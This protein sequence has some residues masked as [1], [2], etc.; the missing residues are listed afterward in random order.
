MFSDKSRYKKTPV[1]DAL[2][3]GG[4]AVKAVAPRVL[5]A[6]TGLPEVVKTN[7]R[8]D[9]TAFQ[10]LNDPL[11]FWRIADANS[12]LDARGLTA[13]PGETINVPES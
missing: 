10:R 1:I 3:P 13:E 4:K 6:T 12:A 8:L 9:L 5:P 2:T 11:A 7:D